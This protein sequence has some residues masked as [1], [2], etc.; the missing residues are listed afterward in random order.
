MYTMVGAEVGRVH[1]PSLQIPDTHV[2]P[3][4]PQLLGS[5]LGLTHFPEHSIS[6]GEQEDR[7]GHATQAPKLQ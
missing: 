4:V 6:T 5:L 3:Q 7:E 1:L 2:V